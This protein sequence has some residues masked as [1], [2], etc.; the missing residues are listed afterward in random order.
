MPNDDTI[1]CTLILR[2]T[3]NAPVARVWRAWTD[4]AELGKWYVADSDHIVHFAEADVR[5][6]GTYRVGFGPPGTTPYIE[7]GRYT[8]IVPMTRLAFAESVSLNGE[9][10]QGTSNIVELRDVGAGRTELVL[11]CT[12]ENSWRSGEGWTPCLQS[13]AAFLETQP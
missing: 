7:T 13:L 6:G 1:D 4:P 3:Y 5:I 8:E 12:G 2:R 10:M 11:T 9:V